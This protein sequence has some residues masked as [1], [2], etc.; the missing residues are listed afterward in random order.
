MA[1][2]HHAI[3]CP[4]CLLSASGFHNS[5]FLSNL[6]PKF[7]RT[8]FK[9][10]KAKQLK[11]K[12]LYAD[13]DDGGYLVDAPVQEGDGFSFYGGNYSEMP[14]RAEEWLKQGKFIK[15]TSIHGAMEKAKDPIFGLA[16][17]KGSQVEEDGFRWFYVEAGNT[18]NHS[19]VL[20]H[21]L[22]SQAYSFRKVLSVLSQD[23]HVI[24]FDWLGFGFSD[25]PQPGYGFDYTIKEY[26][27]SFE[28]L[29][30]VLSISKFTVVSQGYFTPIIAAY[31]KS[32][33]ENLRNLVLINPPLMEQHAKLPSILSSFS[34]FL[35]GEIFSQDPLRASDRLLT[36]CG[37]YLM[38]E[39]D[40]MV[41][42]RPYLT[43]GSSGFAL[44]AISRMLKKGLKDSLVEMRS[45]LSNKEWKVP[46]SIIWGMRDRWLK[47]D[48]VEEFANFAKHEVIQLPKGGHHVQEEYGE[49]VGEII[50][51]IIKKNALK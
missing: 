13:D 41:Y 14:S 25:K 22:P 42:R 46:T 21:G 1:I 37:P 19:V 38:D 43:S 8:F 31:A 47:Y 33:Q 35:L 29:L 26:K 36:S 7:T 50:K 4:A 2:I 16:M 27:A 30:D 40:A 49:E 18:S 6:P 24:A 15:T 20:V 44:T 34:S 11:C 28:S 32:H 3:Q 23:Y 10:T 17:G 12:S 9:A 39:E 48:G 51:R 5:Q 45:I